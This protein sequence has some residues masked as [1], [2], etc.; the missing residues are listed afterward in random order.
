MSRP[1]IMKKCFHYHGQCDIL[2]ITVSIINSRF[3]L[4]LMVQELPE[5]QNMHHSDHKSVTKKKEAKFA[6]ASQGTGIVQKDR[7]K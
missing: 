2:C 1:L 4:D 3:R 5:I 6:I 7:K